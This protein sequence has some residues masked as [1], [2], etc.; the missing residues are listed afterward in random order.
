MDENVGARPTDWE[1]QTQSCCWLIFEETLKRKKFG[2]NGGIELHK[3]IRIAELEDVIKR[4]SWGIPLA[5]KT[6]AEVIS[7]RLY[8]TGYICFHILYIYIIRINSY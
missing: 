7:Q 1:M 3:D 5:A 4:S 8:K 2:D 6:L